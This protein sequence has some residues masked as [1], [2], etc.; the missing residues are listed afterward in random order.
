M[1]FH[2]RD[3]VIHTFLH[4]KLLKNAHCVDCK[5]IVMINL[6][7]YVIDSIFALQWAFNA[8]INSLKR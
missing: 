7:K 4:R 2:Q 3:T 1:T 6:K 8:Y 5:D